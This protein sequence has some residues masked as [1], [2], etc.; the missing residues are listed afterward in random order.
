MKVPLYSPYEKKD[1]TR[2]S[3]KVESG[4]GLFDNNA[5]NLAMALIMS[6]GGMA[7]AL[8]FWTVDW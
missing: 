1:H 4:L 6:V 8:Y 3:R 5:V 7:V 2:S